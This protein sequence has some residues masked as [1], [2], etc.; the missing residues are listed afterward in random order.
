MSK[1]VA[2]LTALSIALPLI[3]PAVLAAP[4][5]VEKQTP[6]RR[7]MMRYDTNNDG[8]V[9]RAEWNAGQEARFKQLDTDKDGKLSR[10]EL[11][12]RTPAA[13]GNVLPTEAQQRRQ[14]SYFRQLDADKDGFVSKAEFMTQAEK[15]FARCDLDKDGRITTAECRQALQRRRPAEP[16]SI[17]R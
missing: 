14:D 9:D 10:D 8:F 6:G 2:A 5:P 11:F 7:G 3:A 15:N 16:A 4:D 17:N 12:A 1:F 13:P